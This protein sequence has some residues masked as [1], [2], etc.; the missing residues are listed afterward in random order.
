METAFILCSC[1]R[2]RSAA[3]IIN[4]D[5]SELRMADLRTYNVVVLGIGFLLIFTAFTT[6]GNIEVSSNFPVAQW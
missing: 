3:G 6:C 4:V 1:T 2:A 5:L